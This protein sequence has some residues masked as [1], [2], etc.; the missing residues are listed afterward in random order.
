[1]SMRMP[2]TLAASSLKLA[3]CAARVLSIWLRVCRTVVVSPTSFF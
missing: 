3:D 2:S 1:M